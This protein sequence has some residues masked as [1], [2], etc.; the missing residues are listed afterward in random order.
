MASC[1][2]HPQKFMRCPNNFFPFSLPPKIST[3]RKKTL[4][5]V[6]ES[7]KRTPSNMG[8]AHLCKQII[9]LPTTARFDHCVPPPAFGLG[10]GG[11]L[12]RVG[13]PPPRSPSVALGISYT[14]F[15]FHCS[16]VGNCSVALKKQS[17]SCVQTPFVCMSH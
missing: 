6:V 10:G 15:F 13:P 8:H 2:P 16:A 5:S 17:H 7:M 3:N 1:L 11:R 9:F 12:T 14:V 4:H